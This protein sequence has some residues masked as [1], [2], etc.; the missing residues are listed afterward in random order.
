M[1]FG[2]G[3]PAIREL[4]VVER[5]GGHPLTVEVEQH[6]DDQTACGVALQETS[7][8]RRGER[9][10]ATGGPLEV[11][12]GEA[13]LGRLGGGCVPTWQRVHA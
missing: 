2:E 4:V 12:V 13:M 9:A 11:P 7:G 3:L 10:H 6:I 8:L 5:D 1:A